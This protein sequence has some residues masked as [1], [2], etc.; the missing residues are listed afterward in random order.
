MKLVYEGTYTPVNV[1]DTITDFR[2]DE[3]TLVAWYPPQHPASSGRVEVREAG[4]TGTS[5]YYPSVFGL[6]IVD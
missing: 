3:A 6:R 2:G 4:A 1:G 5:L